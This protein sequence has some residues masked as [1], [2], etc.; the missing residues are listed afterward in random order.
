MSI[1]YI[2]SALRKLVEQRAG[3]RCEYCLLPA[4]I[5]FF[6][7]EIDHIVAEKH[8]GLT[9]QDNLA[10]TCWR[11][12]RYKGTDLGSFDPATNGFCFLFHPR[13][14]QW[15]EHF[16]LQ[17]NEI[18]GITPEGRTTIKLLK[19]NSDERVVERRKIYAD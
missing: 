1:T 17:D 9:V 16:K 3:Y 10:Y 19:L 15:Q 5:S 4:G 7:H 6:P 2:P 11:C 13:S 14:Q 12:N 18:I 8:G